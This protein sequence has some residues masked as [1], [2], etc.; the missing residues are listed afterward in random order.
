M[1]FGEAAIRL[2]YHIKG[3]GIPV[4]D[5]FGQW[6]IES[7]ERDAERAEGRQMR[8]K[9]K[10]LVLPR[11]RPFTERGRFSVNWTPGKPDVPETQVV[12]MTHRS[13][14]LQRHLLRTSPRRQSGTW[15][16]LLLQNEL[17]GRPETVG[18]CG[19]WNVM[20]TGHALAIE[21]TDT[22]SFA[23][24]YVAKEAS[25]RNAPTLRSPACYRD[26]LIV[27]SAPD[28]VS[29]QLVFIAPDVGRYGIIP[30]K[31][32]AQW[33]MRA[34]SELI[35]VGGVSYRTEDLLKRLNAGR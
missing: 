28:P 19:R 4:T 18:T 7:L 15:G 12:M 21:H 8:Q 26:M 33:S 11:Q 29:R 24:L 5:S 32:D 20:S 30:L 10:P 25:R 9:R 23:W 14:G 17:H 1:L 35:N 34:N 27:E 2:P 6:V 16:L 3:T 31:P 13:E 22:D